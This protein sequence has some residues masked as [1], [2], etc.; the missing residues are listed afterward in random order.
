[1]YFFQNALELIQLIIGKTA[2]YTSEKS[3]TLTDGFLA[4]TMLFN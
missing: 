2:H 4:E 1:M 3:S